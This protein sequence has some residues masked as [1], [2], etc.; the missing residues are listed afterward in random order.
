MELF[1]LPP[2]SL[3]GS[4]VATLDYGGGIRAES[5]PFI[6][7]FCIWWNGIPEEECGS[8]ENVA[9]TVAGSSTGGRQS[10]DKWQAYSM[11]RLAGRQRAKSCDSVFWKAKAYR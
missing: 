5:D 4:F 3:H 1:G 7:A 11:V 8:T 9:K 10:L 6:G 2:C